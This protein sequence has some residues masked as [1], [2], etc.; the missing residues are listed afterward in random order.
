M[1]LSSIFCNG[2]VLAANKPIRVF[3]T[4]CG[5]ATV[6]FLGIE[7]NVVSDDGQWCVELPAMGYGGPYEMEI[8]LDGAPQLLEDVYVGEVLLLHGQSNIQFRLG[9][10]SYPAEQYEA[11]P[12]LRLFSAPKYV[13]GE[14]KSPMEGWVACTH[15]TAAVFSAIGYHVG[16]EIAKERDC[17]VGLIACC[18]GASVIQT[19]LS[20]GTE[21]ALGICIADED[22]HRD[23]F[24]E[25]YRN[26]NQ[27]GYLYEISV[28]PLMPYSLSYVIWYQGESN[29]TA[30]EGAAYD[31]LL[32]ALIEQRRRDFADADL[33][34]VVVELAECLARA[35]EGWT[36]V[37]QAQNRV[38]GL[39]FGVQTVRCADVCENDNIHP[40]TKIY[41]SERIAGV[42]L[43][44]K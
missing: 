27:E 43:G 23:H 41:L 4:G 29:A 26:W 21:R 1:K 24:K 2:M 38:A 25:P 8:E 32:T 18:Q 19:W 15:Q 9:E 30:A 10:S 13:N 22:R 33:P 7:K 28:K 36:L 34:F 11:C 3:G 42:I 31:M 16:L 5:Q 14:V 20:R 40:P 17:A 6:R 44:K 37:Q 39:V 35:G 12:R